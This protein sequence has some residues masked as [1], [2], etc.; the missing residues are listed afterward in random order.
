MNGAVQEVLLYIAE[1]HSNSITGKN[2]G[3][4]AAH[5]SGS[6]HSYGF[7][8]HG[9]GSRVP[10]QDSRWVFS[11]PDEGVPPSQSR[12]FGIRGLRTKVRK[13]SSGEFNQNI[14]KNRG[15]PGD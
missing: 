5:G 1:Q 3:N 9:V 11:R 13:I 7:D 2:L 10:Q 14:E 12:I 6:D 4:A 8:F 15:R